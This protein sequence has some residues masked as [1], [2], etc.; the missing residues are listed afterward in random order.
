MICWLRTLSKP[1]YHNNHG[2]GKDMTE[3]H[4]AKVFHRLMI[5]GKIREAVR[6][7]TSRAGG[8]Q[9]DPTERVG[10]SGRTVHDVLV[11]KHPHPREADLMTLPSLGDLP[12]LV[13][14]EVTETTVDRV[15][16]RLHGSAGPSG[17]DTVTCANWL[18]R[19]GADSRLLRIEVAQMTTWMGNN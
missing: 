17:I 1:T 10:D 2:G 14:L 15:A 3:D 19:F 13:D 8:G 9:M 11:S 5:Q 16:R 7:I 12:E 4:R 18:L 6:F